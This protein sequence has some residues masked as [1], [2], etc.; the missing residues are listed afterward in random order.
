MFGNIHVV[1]N[2]GG[3]NQVF[4]VK[5]KML[6]HQPF[7]LI[8]DNDFNNQHILCMFTDSHSCKTGFLNSDGILTVKDYACSYNS[9]TQYNL[10]TFL[11]KI[12]VI[13]KKPKSFN[14]YGLDFN[15]FVRTWDLGSFSRKSRETENYNPLT[16]ILFE[17]IEINE[18]VLDIIETDRLYRQEVHLLFIT[19]RKIIVYCHTKKII[20]R[21]YTHDEIGILKVIKNEFMINDY[22]NQNFLIKSLDN[23]S[24]GQCS[25]YVFNEV[26]VNNHIYSF[27]LGTYLEIPGPNETVVYKCGTETTINGHINA[28]YASEHSIVFSTTSNNLYIYFVKGRYT[29]MCYEFFRTDGVPVSVAQI[30]FP[31]VKN[32]NDTHIV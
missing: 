8:K 12:I 29:G 17:N 15:G 1:L 2:D 25:K 26:L 31:S 16:P 20:L 7:K 32:A 30:S 23:F 3:I 4:E 6:D 11:K 13:T 22:D 5:G 27:S 21:E 10:Q 28:M 19:K 18:K 24:S 14:I 9:S